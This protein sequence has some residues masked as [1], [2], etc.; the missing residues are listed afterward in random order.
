M[1]SRSGR[2]SLIPAGQALRHRRPGAEQCTPASTGCASARL[3]PHTRGR[4]PRGSRQGKS[5]PLGHET[6]PPAVLVA[7]GQLGLRSSRRAA[8][9]RARR[10]RVSPPRTRGGTEASEGA[11]GRS[12]RPQCPSRASEGQFR[13]EETR[14]EPET[15]LSQNAPQPTPVRTVVPAIKLDLSVEQRDAFRPS[16]TGRCARRQARI[17]AFQHARPASGSRRRGGRNHSPNARAAH[18]RWLPSWSG[19][20][21]SRISS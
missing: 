13:A 7:A 11:A 9:N 15:N 21:A 12:A 17:P 2:R 20:S 16:R 8:T 18:H 1:L 6:R 10:C 4:S 19:G 14:Q 5:A 3:E